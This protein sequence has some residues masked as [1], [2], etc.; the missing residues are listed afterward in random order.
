MENLKPKN[1]EKIKKPKEDLA[2][3]VI[4]NSLLKVWDCL[5]EM[6]TKNDLVETEII[7]IKTIKDKI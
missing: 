4:L 3:S 7:R 5:S 2:I 6:G 1:L